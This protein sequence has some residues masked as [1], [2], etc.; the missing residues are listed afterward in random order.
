MRK[1]AFW[2]QKKLKIHQIGSYKFF[3]QIGRYGYQKLT[4]EKLDFL[5][6]F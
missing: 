2:A 6:D 3:L 1:L 5:R 4:T